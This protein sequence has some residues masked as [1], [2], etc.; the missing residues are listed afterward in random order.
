M[1]T[2]KKIYLRIAVNLLLSIIGLLLLI[3]V[4]PKVINFLLPFVIAFIVSCIANPLVK[5]LEKKLNIVRKHGS[6]IIIVLVIAMVLLILYGVGAI[7][8]NQ[9][10][11]LVGDAQTMTTTINDT[12]AKIQQR[13][14]GLYVKLPENMQQ[15]M[16]EFSLSVEKNIGSVM[17]RIKWPTFEAASGYLKNAVEF[18][19]Y[20]IVTLLASYFFTVEGENIAAEI[21]KIV[22]KS[23]IEYY[24]MIVKNF[25][26]AVGGYFSTQFKL[27]LIIWVYL[28]IGFLFIGVKYAF[29][30][31]F[32]VAFLDLLPVFGTG[33]VIGPWVVICLLTGDYFNAIYLTILYLVCQLVKQLLQPKM[34]GDKIGVSPLA[35]LF[36][37]FVG[38]KIGGFF[39]LI[40]GIPFGM[41]LI[42]LYQMGF[43]N[44]LIKGIQIISHDINEYR[45][46]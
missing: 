25:K 41:I 30:F 17:N 24:S 8:F 42:S 14:D 28:F 43:F 3:F 21:K 16:G 15:F 4:V 29:L 13:L 31:A 23:I 45:K 39:G 36:F 7:L 19:F 6:V 34:V 12:L 22:P 46:Y 5:L 27:M 40:I 44:R 35:T 18:I 11:G 10:K 20:A 2:N 9:V 33:T 26:A 32:F 1:K 38:Y 37:M